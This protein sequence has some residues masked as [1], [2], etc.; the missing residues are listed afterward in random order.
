MLP[1]T[2][3]Q[4]ELRFKMVRMVEALESRRLMS[5]DIVFP[6][7]SGLPVTLSALDD[8]D[9]PQFTMFLMAEMMPP[10]KAALGGT[11]THDANGAIIITF[12]T[13]ER[14]LLPGVKSDGSVY[15]AGTPSADTVT[16]ERVTGLDSSDPSLMGV[17]YFPMPE[18][19][20]DVPLVGVGIGA[21]KD[22][23]KLQ[24]LLDS[25][26]A[27]LAK[28]EQELA[29]RQAAITD[30]QPDPDPTGTEALQREIKFSQFSVDELQYV[31]AKIAE[32][33]DYV[34]YRLDGVYEIFVDASVGLTIQSRIRIDT[35]DG[36][37]IVSVAN[38]V[39]LRSTVSGGSGPDKLTSGSKRT[40]LYGGGGKDRLFSR[41][42]HGGTLDG[43][44]GADKYYNRFGEIQI[45]AR[46]DGDAIVVN[47]R[48]IIVAQPGIFGI[49]AD[50]DTGLPTRSYFLIDSDDGLEDI[51]A[52]D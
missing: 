38:N 43:G 50:A 23:T 40:L 19:V 45:S 41:S 16:V 3:W 26:G 29:D 11:S 13:G 31:L 34:R 24:D 21:I 10:D 39:P 17:V 49:T 12:P 15:L 25:T 44:T 22:P 2:R 36:A 8:S 32:P 48:P 35:G 20:S 46:A 4:Q 51:L 30:D 6:P 5:A 42:K 37:D 28:K 18:G 27:S 1:E 7:E 33:V 47:D 9:V 14:I 52:P